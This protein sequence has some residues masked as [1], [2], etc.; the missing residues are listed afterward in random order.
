[1]IRLLQLLLLLI[2]AAIA[3][4]LVKR[5]LLPPADGGEPPRVVRTGRCSRCGTH[6]PAAD[7]DSASVCPRC[8]SGAD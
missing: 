8:R 2:L 6:V 1:M 5:W 7:L 3:W 4:R